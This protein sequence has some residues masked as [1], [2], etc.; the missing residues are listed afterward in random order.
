MGASGDLAKKKIYPTIWWLYRDGLLPA[1][2]TFVGY[3]RS[4]MT[5]EQLR[6]KCQPYMK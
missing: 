1:N 2:T 6:E 4:K 5:V 3:A